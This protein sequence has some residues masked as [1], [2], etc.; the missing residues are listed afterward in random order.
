MTLYTRLLFLSILIPFILSFDKKVSFYRIWRSLLPSSVIVGAVYIAF[1]ILFVKK[2]IWGFNPDYHSGII[3]LGL[4]FEEWLFFILIPYSCIFIHYV[5]ISYWPALK[6]SRRFVII[7]SSVLI[8]ILLIIIFLNFDKAY[9]LF[10]FSLLIIALLWAMAGKSDI[11]SRYYLSFIIILIPFFIVN[12]ILTGT[13]IEGE[14]VWYNNFETLG[15]R[16]G[17]VPVEDIGYAFSLILLNLLFIS[18]FQKLFSRRK[19]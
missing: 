10:N 8:L 3:F 6:L 9:T 13:F 19:S 11:L 15:I 4:P 14:A 2:G 12:S 5:F 16:L 7:L 17:T 1:D 18:V